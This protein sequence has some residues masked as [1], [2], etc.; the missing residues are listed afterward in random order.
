MSVMIYDPLDWEKKVGYRTDMSGRCRAHVS[1]ERCSRHQCSFAGKHL[2][3]GYALCTRHAKEFDKNGWFGSAPTEPKND[4][5]SACKA[6]GGE[7]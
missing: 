3:E 2:R 7:Q 5:P 4:P 1:G 6:V